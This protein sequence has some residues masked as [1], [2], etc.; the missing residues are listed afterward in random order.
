MYD[1]GECFQLIP[2]SQRTI[3]FI[4]LKTM[5]INQ[6]IGTLCLFS[7]Y[8]LK[9][10]QKNSNKCGLRYLPDKTQIDIPPLLCWTTKN[11][12]FF[13]SQTNSCPTMAYATPFIA[14]KKD[15]KHF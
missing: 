8:E 7:V 11:N 2:R 10:D 1:K 5:E 13:S 3:K 9:K 12:I 14:Y 15:I 4:T 6:F